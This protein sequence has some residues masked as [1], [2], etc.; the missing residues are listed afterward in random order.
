MKR[1]IFV[2]LTIAL[3]FLLGGALAAT[4]Q[5]LSADGTITN[6][7][8]SATI[9]GAAKVN[10]PPC[11][12]TIIDAI[13]PGVPS[14]TVLT[15]RVQIATSTPEGNQSN[16]QTLTT[17]VASDV[18]CT[19]TEN[20][21]PI[22]ITT[23]LFSGSL[24]QTFQATMNWVNGLGALPYGLGRP[25]AMKDVPIHH[26]ENW[27]KEF[28]VN[29]AASIELST[30]SIDPA[31]SDI[32][33]YLDK[34]TGTA[35]QSIANSGGP[36]ADEHIKVKFP[37]DGHYRARVYGYSVAGNGKFDFSLN[38]IQGTDLTVNLPTGP[39][40]A[41]QMVT[42]TLNFNKY[43]A[44]C[45]W[46]GVLYVGPAE[47]P[48]TWEIPVTIYFDTPEYV[49]STKSIQTMM[50]D[51]LVRP[52]ETV[53][54]TLHFQNTG[55]GDARQAE[56]VD[57]IPAGTTYVPGSA[58]GGTVYEPANNRVRWSSVLGAGIS[59][60]FTWKVKVNDGVTCRQPI[61]NT[62]QFKD[63]WT[64]LLVEKTQT[65]LV[66]C[67]GL[68]VTKTGPA[69]VIPGFP[70]TYTIAYANAGPDTALDVYVDDMLPAGV[71]YVS[72]NPAGVL[73]NAGYIRWYLGNLAV[74]ANGTITLVGNVDT[75]MAEGSTL[76]NTA[77][78]ATGI[79]AAGPT[80]I[81][82]D[83]NLANN[84][85]TFSTTV[86]VYHVVIAPKIASIEVGQTQCYTLT[87]T[88]NVDTWD[89][90]LN[91]RTTYTITPAA[92]GSWATNCY[93]AAKA[94]TWT[95]T[96]TYL[97]KSNT[98]MLTVTITPTPT[99]TPTRTPTAMPTATP[100]RT[101][102]PT[103]TKTLTPARVARVYLPIIVKNYFPPTPIPTSTPTSTPTPTPWCDPYEPNNDRYINPWGALQSA[104][105]YQAKL[106]IGD[107]EDNYYFDVGT[108]NPVQLYLQ[109][110]DS[111]RTLT[112]IWLYTQD[113]LDQ[114]ISG[115]G[116][117]VNTSEYTTTCSIP[118]LGRYIIRLYTDGVAD[119]VDSYTLQATFQ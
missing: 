88:D 45:Y 110:P 25:T 64:G 63:N 11:T 68:S 79:T 20:P 74:G 41:G 50:P 89:L 117:W 75:T 86:P 28:D 58:T 24:N 62:A 38:T 5:N 93:T 57:A 114:P 84:S 70:I 48:T 103:L 66:R 78:I 96:G 116:G 76:V 80:Y 35:W 119:D 73:V 67:S 87:A 112:A 51:G 92:G 2:A 71:T 37:A 12:Q 59:K 46:Y 83:P 102:T 32:D 111:L 100:T 109:L 115:C 91:V 94:G 113:H 44:T 72:S 13:S 85:A 40:A 43:A 10:F 55:C 56:V 16:N 27:Y 118:E 90:T 4:P 49:N 22:W 3:A 8:M 18:P 61:A 26:G 95:V 52:G 23:T 97:S 7:R 1:V 36:T 6:L 17:I 14:R 34:W 107:A 106:C 99:S 30:S 108:T 47:A 69:K 65:V 29:N 15:N 33:L 81:T 19:G 53:T 104:Q 21:S 82:P 60:D 105:S 101:P 39:I 42:F 9:G 54:Y 77:A 31:T 98:A